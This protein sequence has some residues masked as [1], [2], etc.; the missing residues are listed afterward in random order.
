MGVLEE[1]MLAQLLKSPAVSTLILGAQVVLM[2]V[3]AVALLIVLYMA[4]VA[5]QV[6]TGLF[7]LFGVVTALSHLQTLAVLHK[8]MNAL[9]LVTA[10][11]LGFL[12]KCQNSVRDFKLLW[13][14]LDFAQPIREASKVIAVAYNEWRHLQC[15]TVSVNLEQS[16]RMGWSGR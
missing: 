5:E 9:V 11:R 14:G 4:A 7:V 3:V 15:R 2:A 1:P 8:M 16:G 12:G 13:A 6:L 10:Y